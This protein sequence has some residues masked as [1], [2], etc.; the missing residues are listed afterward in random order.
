[1]RFN[2]GLLLAAGVVGYA[3]YQLYQKR[4][5]VIDLIDTTTERLPKISEDLQHISDQL[6]VIKSYRPILNEMSRDLTKRY[7]HLQTEGQ[8]RLEVINRFA[9]KYF[10]PED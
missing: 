2:T 9:D 4:Q 10:P 6:D 1:M 3:G 5:E 7:Q 8:H